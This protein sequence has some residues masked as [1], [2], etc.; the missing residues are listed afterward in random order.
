[1]RRNLNLFYTLLTVIIFLLVFGISFT[2]WRMIMN[3]EKLIEFTDNDRWEKILEENGYY[4]ENLIVFFGDSQIA[5]WSMCP[6]FGTMPIKN[7]GI[8]G[9]WASESIKRYKRDI[10]ALNADAIFILSGSNDLR[11]SVKIETITE[12]IEIMILESKKDSINTI[13]GSILPVNGK[14]VSEYSFQDI[15]DLNDS[16]QAICQKH[17]SIYVDFFNELVNDEG[18]FNTKFTDDGLHPNQEGYHIMTRMLVP[19]LRKY[20]N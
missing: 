7:R 9:D 18:Y 15:L 8:S 17:N 13:V 14:Y 2:T 3:R 5:L 10:L 20:L 16:L 1:M 6:Y 11:N 12:N 4:K 19:I